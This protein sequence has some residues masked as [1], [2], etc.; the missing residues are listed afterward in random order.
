MRGIEKIVYQ[1]LEEARNEQSKIQEQTHIEIEK[2]QGRTRERIAEM[3][4]KNQ[5]EIQA[6][7]KRIEDLSQLTTDQKNRRAKL[8]AKQEMIGK[9]VDESYRELLDMEKEE[10]LKLIFDMVEKFALPKEGKIYFNRNDL[11]LIDDETAAKISEIAKGKGGNLTL[12]G[13]PKEID[14]GFIL[15]YGGIE[16]N[17]TFKALMDSKK[18]ELQDLIRNILFS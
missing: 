11:N 17:C 18:D 16:E 10:Y 3:G 9:I 7:I 6:A 4:K 2:I 15:T 14:R 12:A 1:I 13:E 8:E 5:Q